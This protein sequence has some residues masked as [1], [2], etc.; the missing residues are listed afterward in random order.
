MFGR[1][2]GRYDLLNSLM[3]L[4][5]DR[6]WRKE[7]IRRLEVTGPARLLDLGTGTAALAEGILAQST[8]VQV[9]GADFSHEMLAVGRQRGLGTRVAWVLAD[10]LHLPFADGTFD[11]VVSGFLLRNVADVDLSLAEQYRVLRSP[12]ANGPG[13]RIVCLE[14]TPPKRSALRP[15]LDLHLH[16]IIPTLGRWLAGDVEAY[17]YLP[18]STEDFFSA[19]ALAARLAGAGFTGIGFVRRMFG[20]VAIHWGQKG[21]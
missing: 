17:R 11:G 14:T 1:I 10:A 3:T 16:L 15:F 8:N 19:E 9:I 13:G 12:R 21:R 4:G 20:T 6:R 18:I 7:A 5:L 2:A